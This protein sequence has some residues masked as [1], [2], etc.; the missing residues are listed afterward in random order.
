M[1]AA[2]CL[3]VQYI[4]WASWFTEECLLHH[5][6]HFSYLGMRRLK[7][8]CFC[9][10][11]LLSH[12]LTQQ[13]KGAEGIL[14]CSCK[15]SHVLW[16]SN[17]MVD[18]RFACVLV[19]AMGPVFH[20]FLSLHRLWLR[21]LLF[22]VRYVVSVLR[23]DAEGCFLSDFI[24]CMISGFSL[25]P[26]MLKS[27]ES[28]IVKGWPRAKGCGF[29][30][31][32]KHFSFTFLRWDLRKMFGYA[33]GNVWKLRVDVIPKFSLDNPDPCFSV[34]AVASLDRF[35]VCD[36]GIEALCH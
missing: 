18:F 11:P 2:K 36:Y 19:N 15:I 20:E 16:S 6:T 13:A 5:T 30:S 26:Y 21:N 24:K 27:I 22:S 3:H 34:S 23:F 4:L 29:K 7:S 17:G 33:S 14:R 35:H 32:I 8:S 1:T 31:Q 9:L 28:N 12:S 25:G 10:L